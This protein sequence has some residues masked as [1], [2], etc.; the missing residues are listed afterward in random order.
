MI[1][2]QRISLHIAG[3]LFVLMSGYSTALKAKEVG[4]KYE[5]VTQLVGNVIATP[6]SIVMAN[7][8]QT[9]DFSS[10]TLTQLSTETLREE[11]AQSFD[12]EL[13]DCGSVYSSVDSKTWTIRFEGPSAENINAFVLQG[14]ST[15][16]GVSVHNNNMQTLVPGQK[17]TLNN[18]VLRQSKSGNTLFLRYFLQLELTGQPI[19]AGRY[20]G[21][22]RFFIDYQ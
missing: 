12:I 19:Q 7:R 20:H 4:I 18:N 8:D 15:G 11:H 22:V 3:I 21:L 9:V 2:F 6:C 16:L 5:G 10:L 17:Y 14:P 13:H 1:I